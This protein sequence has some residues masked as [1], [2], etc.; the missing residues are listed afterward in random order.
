M[1]SSN[2]NDFRALALCEGSPQTQRANNA[3]FDNFML[4]QTNGLTYSRVAGDWRHHDAH[5]DVTVMSYNCPSAAEASD[6]DVDT[7]ITGIHQKIRI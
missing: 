3:G 1:A 4:V 7:N 2:G 6:Q 5:R